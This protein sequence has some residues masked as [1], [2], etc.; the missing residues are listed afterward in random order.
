VAIVV[1][2]LVGLAGVVVGCQ[3]ARDAQKTARD[4]QRESARAQ[5]EQA[6]L[7]ELRLVLDRAAAD[8]KRVEAA[9]K[10]VIET[11]RVRP[12][13][14]DPLLSTL[15]TAQ[16]TEVRLE[17]RLGRQSDAVKDFTDATVWFSSV[18]SRRERG[19]GKGMEAVDRF[20]RDAQELAGSQL[21]K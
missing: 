1:G 2:G 21:P 9:A 8:L 16:S 10:A 4:A 7:T 14:L 19:V 15:R 12:A 5:R 13:A 6:D 3:S 17:I 11:G 20:L 18:V